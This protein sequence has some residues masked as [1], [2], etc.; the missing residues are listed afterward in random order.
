M[1]PLHDARIHPLSAHA[2]AELKDIRHKPLPRSTVNP[3]V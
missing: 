3:G 1:I 2:V